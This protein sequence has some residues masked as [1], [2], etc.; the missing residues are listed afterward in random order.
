M[1][2][3]GAKLKF[4][5]LYGKTKVNNKQLYIELMKRALFK[6]KNNNNYVL[7]TVVKLAK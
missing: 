1:Y 4:N 7:I 5:S 6:K 2:K 3:K